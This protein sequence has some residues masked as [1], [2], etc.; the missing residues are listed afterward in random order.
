MSKKY[1]PAKC[2]ALNA[3]I[4]EFNM[5]VKRVATK[6][7]TL[8]IYYH[9]Q[10]IGYGKDSITYVAHLQLINQQCNKKTMLN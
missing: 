4:D 2:D 7:E 5:H 8:V 1:T 6:T 10:F 9:A 3:E